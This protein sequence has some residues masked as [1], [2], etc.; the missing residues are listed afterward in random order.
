[1]SFDAR[2][3]SAHHIYCSAI[4]WEPWKHNSYQAAGRI[5]MICG[6]NV[7]GSVYMNL[8]RKVCGFWGCNY[9]VVT[10]GS[11]I[12]KTDTVFITQ[13]AGLGESGT[14]R[15]RTSSASGTTVWFDHPPCCRAY[16]GYLI[17]DRELF[18]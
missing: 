8:E 15:Y 7:Y 2:P 5:D 14:H 9:H 12:T 3:A 13:V 16:A 10:Y 17:A 4:A 11:P 18:F 1:V 6:A